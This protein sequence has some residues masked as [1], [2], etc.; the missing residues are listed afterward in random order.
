MED[1]NYG[2]TLVPTFPIELDFLH[3]SRWYVTFLPPGM[4]EMGLELAKG[5]RSEVA[6]NRVVNGVDR[7][8][9]VVGV[10]CWTVSQAACMTFCNISM[11]A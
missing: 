7:I 5:Q 3:N 1:E 9:A 11:S 10:S 4:L 2:R 6:S 8:V